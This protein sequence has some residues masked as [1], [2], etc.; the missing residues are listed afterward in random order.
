MNTN[1]VAVEFLYEVRDTRTNIVVDSDRNQDQA[2]KKA[3]SAGRQNP[4]RSF[5]IVAIPQ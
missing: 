4:D 5:H 1:N 2:R 3:I